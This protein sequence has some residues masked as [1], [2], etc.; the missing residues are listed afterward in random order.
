MNLSTLQRIIFN[1]THAVVNGRWLTLVA[2]R[3]ERRAERHVLVQW[4]ISSQAQFFVPPTKK[5]IFI[6][7]TST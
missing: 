1:K 2:H 6:T 5:I 4:T 7:G 3:L